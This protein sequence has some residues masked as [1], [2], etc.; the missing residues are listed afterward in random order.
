M[1][2]KA[3]SQ[4]Y[5]GFFV[6]LAAYLVDLLVVGIALLIVRIPIWIM[7]F[8][9][10][11]NFIVRDMI[12]QYSIADILLYLLKVVYFVLLTYYTGSTLGKKLF[13]I[14]VVSTENRKMTFFEVVFRETVGRFLA[15]LIIYVGYIMVGVDKQKR[16]LHDILSDTQVIY[17]HEKKVYT[18][19]QMN[20]RNMNQTTYTTQTNYVDNTINKNE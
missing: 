18:H 5:A 12:F 6:R 11:D 1:Q 10:P 16:G 3:D 9:N 15:A 14:K 19:A 20:Y 4:L 17:Y 7:S 2:N 13:Q 8:I